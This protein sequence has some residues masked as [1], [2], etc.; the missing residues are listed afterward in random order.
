MHIKHYIHFSKNFQEGRPHLWKKSKKK[1]ATAIFSWPADTEKRK[2]SV[3]RK[4]NFK[5]GPPH[6]WKK[7]KKKDRNQDTS[8]D[9]LIPKNAKKMRFS[10]K[11]FKG[12][13][14]TY[15]KKSKKKPAIRTLLLTHLSLKT[16]NNFNVSVLMNKKI[17][18]KN[19]FFNL[20]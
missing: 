7:S 4:K 16:Q 12:V 14:L 1:P 11:N 2:K 6:L 19:Y 8:L 10:Q 15:E 13:P 3:F 9:P 18:I 5:G 20:F 17:N